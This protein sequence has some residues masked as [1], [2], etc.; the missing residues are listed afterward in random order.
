MTRRPA[1]G[2]TS[3]APVGVDYQG[4]QGTHGLLPRGWQRSA[5][6]TALFNHAPG[7]LRAGLRTPAT[8]LVSLV[9]RS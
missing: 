7:P 9:R 5:A 1:T 3:P 4:T 6:P 2:S 8:L